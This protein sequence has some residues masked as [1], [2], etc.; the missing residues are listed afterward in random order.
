MAVRIDI[1]TDGELAVAYCKGTLTVEDKLE[2]RSQLRALLPNHPQLVLEL[3]ELQA[4][5]SAGVGALAAIYTSYRDFGG[6][7]RLAGTTPQVRRTLE[8]CG[9]TRIMRIFDD[10]AQAVK[11]YGGAAGH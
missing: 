6:D 10:E 8:V 2:F 7:I 9:L 4:I 11:S 3:G 5:D 1:R